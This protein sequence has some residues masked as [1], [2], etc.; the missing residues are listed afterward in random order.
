MNLGQWYRE[1]AVRFISSTW[2]VEGSKDSKRIRTRDRGIL[3]QL[4][5]KI[6]Q[7]GKPGLRD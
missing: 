6:L 3:T 7:D 4:T 1:M 5:R 2:S